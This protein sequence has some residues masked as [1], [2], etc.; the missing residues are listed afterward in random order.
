M[1]AI[2]NILGSQATRDADGVLYTRAGLEIGVAATK[3][4]VAQ[5][6]AMYLIG[7]KLAELRGT[8]EPA[9]LE[10]LI[11]EL[12]AIPHRIDTLLA[13]MRRSRCGRSPA[14]TPSVTSSSTSAGTSA[15]RCASRAR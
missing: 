14:R 10:G 2:T 13:L 4:F 6:A 5:V 7:L 8:M 15:C 12:K 11:G 3:T 1:L 9:E